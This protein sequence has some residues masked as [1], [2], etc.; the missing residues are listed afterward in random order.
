MFRQHLIES[1]IESCTCAAAFEPRVANKRYFTKGRKVFLPTR[2]RPAKAIRTFDVA[3]GTSFVPNG[4]PTTPDVIYI[5]LRL[6]R[7]ARDGDGRALS[8][9][10]R[11]CLGKPYDD[12]NLW[13]G[14]D[15]ENLNENYWPL[16]K[17]FE[18]PKDHADA[19]TIKKFVDQVCED[20]CALIKALRKCNSRN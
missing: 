6:G 19:A 15:T 12:H 10:L 16:Y 1:I 2:F 5:G 9:A 20:I 13:F 4:R 3:I 18:V 11:N 8:Q 14:P 17:N 7:D